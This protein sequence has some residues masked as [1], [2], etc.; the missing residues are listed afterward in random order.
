MLAVS[1]YGWTNLFLILILVLSEFS[2]RKTRKRF[3]PVTRVVRQW[4]E[5]LGPRRL[6][7]P[8]SNRDPTGTLAIRSLGLD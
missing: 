5:L 3:V 6:R 1:S 4:K 7:Q 2:T 8:R